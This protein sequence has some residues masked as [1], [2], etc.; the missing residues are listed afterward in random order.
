MADQIVGS[1][2]A[3]IFG[4]CRHLNVQATTAVYTIADPRNPLQMIYAFHASA[5]CQVCGVPFRF[6][7]D[8]Q[9]APANPLEALEGKRGAWVSHA[10]DEVACMLAPFDVD[11]SL[12]F[13]PAVGRA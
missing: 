5:R 8:N 7:G 12:S 10:G 13:T 11:N 9:L 6:L 4:D 3:S 1:P 2:L